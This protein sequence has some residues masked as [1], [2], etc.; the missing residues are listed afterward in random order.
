MLASEKQYAKC[1]QPG[2]NWCSV[3]LAG[4]PIVC[5]S[6]PV[7]G[8]LENSTRNNHSSVGSSSDKCAFSNYGNSAEGV[9]KKNVK[10]LAMLCLIPVSLLLRQ[11]LKYL[12]LKFPSHVNVKNLKMSLMKIFCL[13]L[14]SVFCKP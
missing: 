4:A 9:T 8:V 14:L 6:E 10:S 13:K 3:K 11:S 1:F 12:N 2:K 7:M 5:G